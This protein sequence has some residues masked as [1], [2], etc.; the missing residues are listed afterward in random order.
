MRLL[1]ACRTNLSPIFGL[2]ADQQAA[3]DPARASRQRARRTWSCDDDAGVRHRAVVAHGA[4]AI[5]AISG[6]LRR[7]TDLHR[8]RAPPLRNR[9]W[10]TARSAAPQGATDPE[11]PHNFILMYL[12]SMSDPGLVI[13]PTHRVLSGMRPGSMRRD[14]L[15]RLRRPLPTHAVCAISARG[16]P[17]LL[18]A[19]Q[20]RSRALASRWRVPMSCSSRRSRTPRRSSEYAAQLAPVVRRL[21][22]TVLD[23]R[24]PAR[25]A[26]HRLHR[27]GAGRDG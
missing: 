23:T 12:T 8:R 27:G 25:A 2:F 15:A 17:R 19:Q 18:C 10:R 22:V 20:P 7:R 6:T 9:R 16:V 21:D 13:L 24:H 3:L 5:A 4:A 14:L 11:A 1:R 26:G